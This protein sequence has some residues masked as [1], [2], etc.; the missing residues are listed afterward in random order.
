MIAEAQSMVRRKRKAGG[1]KEML[2]HAIKLTQR[3][4]FL[5]EEVR[6]CVCVCVCVFHQFVCRTSFFFF[7]IY[8]VHFK[9]LLP[10][11]AP[12]H[13]ARRVCV[14]AKQQQARGVRSAAG[15]RPAVRRQPGVPRNPLWQ[16]NNTVSKGEH[17]HTHT[18]T[19][20]YPI[21]I[22]IFFL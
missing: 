1:E 9:L 11:A 12:A 5:V 18:R 2:Q 10:A 21:Y 6:D 8:P 3:L 13:G 7:L 14:V 17:T 22:Y 20:G 16:D 19:F 15:Q 4:C